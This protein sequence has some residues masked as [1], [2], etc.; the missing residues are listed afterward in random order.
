MAHRTSRRHFLKQT[1]LVGTAWLL[2]SFLKAMAPVGGSVHRKLVVVQLSG[3]NDGLNTVV[4]WRND[5]YH[6]NRQ[7]LALPKD[8]LL[9]IT[10]EFAFNPGALGLKRLHDEGLL[11]VVQGVGYPEPDRSHFRSL[12]IWHSASA[13]NEYWN[14]GWLGRYLDQRGTAPHDVIE[15][16]S[17]LSLAGRGERIKALTLTDAQRLYRSTREPYFAALA[18]GEGHEHATVSYLYRTMAETYQSAAYVKE[19]M[20]PAPTPGTFLKDDLGKQLRTVAHFINSGL[21]TTAYYVTTSGYDTHTNQLQRHERLLRSLGDNLHAFVEQLKAGGE[22][23]NTLV[24]VF[25]EFGRR[26]KQNA[27]NGTD[28]GTAGPVILIGGG[29]KK[30][31]IFNPLPSLTDLDANGD[32]R[33]SVDFRS[34]Y[35]AVIQEWL[36][37]DARTLVPGARP[38]EGLIS[39]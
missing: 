22:L 26:V 15:V 7:R 20:K 13:S 1:G 16:G 27:S 34:V 30:P 8:R 12:D 28:H 32:M 33:F 19:Q 6:A 5:G 14:T 31:G 21:D 23:E 9:A 18:Q 29:L 3:G 25:S 10:D 11:C 38:L 24:M 35:A 39:A 37:A 36:A 17:T 4:P 2:P